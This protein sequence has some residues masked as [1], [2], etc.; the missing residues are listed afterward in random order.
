LSDRVTLQPQAVAGFRLTAPPGVPPWRRLGIGGRIVVLFH[1]PTR[2]VPPQAVLAEKPP[3][4]APQAPRVLAASIAITGLDRD[5]HPIP[6][7]RVDVLQLVVR[8]VAPLLRAVFFDRDRPALPNRYTMLTSEEARAF[9]IDSLRVVEL[10][11]LQ[12][13]T[14]DV[15]GARLQ[16]HPAAMLTLAGITS[17]DEAPTL[18][19]QRAEYVRDYLEHTWGIARQRIAMQYGVGFLARS[20]QLTDDGRADNRR[21][22]MASDNDTVLAP[23]VTERVEREFNPPTVRFDPTITAS[24]GVR[25]W[26]IA[27]TQGGRAVARYEGDGAKAAA[28]GELVWD[29]NERMIDSAL[30]PLK[31]TLVVEDS[32]GAVTHTTAE[33]PLT[34]AR[35]VRWV[36]GR[37]QREGNRERI[38]YT[39][40]GFDFDSDR[41]SATDRDALAQ[42][43]AIAHKGARATVTGYTDR[44]GDPARNRDLSAARAAATAT[45]MR[46]ELAARKCIGCD[47]VE[48]GA[49]VETS[50][51]TNNTPEG[52]ML[53]RGVSIVVEQDV[54]D[55]ELSMHGQ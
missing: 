6:V 34:V 54:A 3:I 15:A 18:Q 1:A 27:V 39:L 47:V 51:F 32:T 12:H 38:S 42:I 25:H 36:D 26:S 8:Q 35:R 44:I 7:A 49:G 19:H 28:S 46:N 33:V 16:R 5:L 29:I 23:V 43:A 22:E 30:S 21:V 45:A 4:A 20:S 55:D 50:R 52:R 14:L 9:A 13:Q 17:D 24:A 48:I 53:S 41:L 11:E 40:V 2:A 37:V 10:Y 31:A